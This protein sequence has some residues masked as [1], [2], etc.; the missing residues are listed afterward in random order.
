MLPELS[1]LAAQH[2]WLISA[3]GFLLSLRKLCAATKCAVIVGF[4]NVAELHHA[5]CNLIVECYANWYRCKA[6]IAK[7]RAR[8]ATISNDSRS[9]HQIFLM[10]L[11]A[12]CATAPI[13]SHSK[14]SSQ[15]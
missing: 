4:R 14:I 1:S 2:P 11:S 13:S 6:R 8:S 9:Q 3:L 10:I 7:L 5:L 12:H 15:D